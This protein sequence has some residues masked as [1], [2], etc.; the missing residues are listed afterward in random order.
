MALLH[1]I[2]LRGRADDP[3]DLLPK[4]DTG[5][6]E[7][8]AAVQAILADVRER[9]DAAV[10]ELTERFDGVVL[11]DLRVPPAEV[12]AALADADPALVDALTAARDAVRAF[13]EAQ[14][15]PDHDVE[16]DGVLVR[17]RTVPVERAGVYVPGGRG[18]YPSTVLMTAV[19]A[20]VAGVDQVVL[21]VPP[22][23]DTGRVH[24]AVLAAAALAGVDEV[25]AIGGAQAIG[26]M[27]FGTES[28]GPV[29]V[30]VGPGNLYVALAK[31]EVSGEVGIPSAFAGPSE[32]VVVA[33]DATPVEFA[34]VDV[35]VQAEHGPDGLAWLVTW[36]EAAADAIDDAIARIVEA[37]PRRADIESTF[38]RGGHVVLVDG[39]EQAM[40]VANAVA[41]EHLQLMT[42][43][44]E[45]LVPLV[46]HAGGVFC[47]PLAPASLGDY[48]AGPSH[49]L[50]THGSARFGSALT[51]DDFTK[52]V[53]VV[54]VDRAAFERLA[55]VVAT[56]AD[57]EGFAAHADSVRRRLDALAAGQVV[58]P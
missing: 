54:T 43:D 31:K 2:D 16:L 7:P 34:A 50:P 55:P 45:A 37:S 44:P 18:A 1:R 36:S 58:V 32:I 46:R 24:P 39:P 22:A 30:I 40:A 6:D 28:I 41:P 5:G 53:H 10:L 11:D 21:C 15:R 27:A 17:G 33:D 25:Y 35:V 3:R 57:V 38:A 12:A 9:G 47:G 8:V 14:V 13:H 19:P 26:A 49:V 52:Q 51:V 4:P 42:A 20:R 48:A 29:D 56:I 23:R